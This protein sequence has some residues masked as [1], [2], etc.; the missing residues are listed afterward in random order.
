[1][2]NLFKRYQ[3][4]ITVGLVVIAAFIAY[5]IFFTPDTGGPL[6]AAEVSGGT[7]GVVE[8]E[9]ISLLLELR[10]IT[11]D[12]AFFNDERFRALKDFSQEIIPEPVG[13]Q[14]PF[15]PLTP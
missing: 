4:V 14:N 2:M 1:M 7:E 11:L 15:A 3:N 6:T 10:S 5:S 9:L 8:Q 13:R 12:P